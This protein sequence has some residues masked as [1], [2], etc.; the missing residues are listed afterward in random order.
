MIITIF[1]DDHCEELAFPLLLHIGEF[2]YQVERDLHLNPVKYFNQ[3]LLTYIQ[4]FVSDL[5]YTLLHY[6]LPSN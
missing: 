1:N 5:D 2:G 4:Q 6:L 3:C